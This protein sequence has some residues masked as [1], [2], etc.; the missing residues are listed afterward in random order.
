MPFIFY[1]LP[2][3]PSKSAYPFSFT[4][5][6][7]CCT[8]GEGCVISKNDEQK[9][10][11]IH[12]D[13]LNGERPIRYDWRGLKKRGKEDN[14]IENTVIEKESSVDCQFKSISGLTFTNRK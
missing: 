8:W 7:P 3:F 1:I 13:K 4:N 12:F 6:S 2:V 5:V 11:M 9:T 14:V 10:Y